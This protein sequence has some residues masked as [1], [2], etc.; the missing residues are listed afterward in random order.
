MNHQMFTSSSPAVRIVDDDPDI[1]QALSDM[2]EYE[3]YEVQS[4]STGRMLS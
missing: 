2:L 3:G 1:C 4:T